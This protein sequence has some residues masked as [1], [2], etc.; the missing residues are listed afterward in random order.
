MLRGD[1]TRVGRQDVTALAAFS[2]LCI[3]DIQ[4]FKDLYQ[5]RYGILLSDEA[6]TEEAHR[7][8]GLYKAV[9][10]TTQE[11]EPEL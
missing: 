1:V 9:Y 10:E 4:A 8:I 5:N 3:K 2:M 7:L 6:A 11:E